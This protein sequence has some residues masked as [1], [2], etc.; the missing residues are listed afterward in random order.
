MSSTQDPTTQC[1]LLSPIKVTSN[2]SNLQPEYIPLPLDDHD[3]L[4]EIFMD[5]TQQDKKELL[6]LTLQQKNSYEYSITFII[7]I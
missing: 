2:E 7:I 6:A 3:D 5:T 4:S 1:L